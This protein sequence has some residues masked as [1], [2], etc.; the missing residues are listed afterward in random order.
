MNSTIQGDGATHQ[1]RFEIAVLDD[2]Q[3]VALE[4]ADWSMLGRG[5]TVTAFRDHID[6][7]DQLVMRLLPYDIVCVMRERTP[8]SAVILQRLPRLRLIVSTG[9]GNRSIDAEA[10]SRQGIEVANTGYSSTPTIEFTWALILGIAR[11]I[12]S[13]SASVRAGGWQRSIGSDLAGKTLGVLGLGNIGSQ[14]AAIGLAFGMKVIAWSENLTAERATAAG[15]EFVTKSELLRRSDFL[16]VH[17]I[18]SGRTKGLLGEAELAEMKPTAYLINTS[19]GPIVDERALVNALKNQQIAG[20]A[21]D[22]Y[23]IEPLPQDHPYRALPNV[24]ATP[25]L[26]YVSRSLYE[27]FYGDTVKRIQAWIGPRQMAS[28]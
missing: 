12:A 16:S 15:A 20:A 6:D 23:D 14:V 2:Y 24:L 5:A 4:L 13:E 21:L 3:G 25:H 18:L 26:G 8:L 27:T 17:L 28:E 19:R 1:T 10:A 7:E 9:P 22:V 11:H